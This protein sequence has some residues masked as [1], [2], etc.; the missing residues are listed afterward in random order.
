LTTVVSPRRLGISLVV[1]VVLALGALVMTALEPPADAQPGPPT[2]AQLT[3][4]E[5]VVGAPTPDLLRIIGSNLDNGPNVDVTLGEFPGSLVVVSA[6]A[7]E[8]LAGLPSPLPAGDYLLTVST[9]NGPSRQDSYDLT[10]ERIE[11]PVG[12][13]ILWDQSN[14][15]PDGFARVG[16]YDGRFLVADGAAG[17]TGGSSFHSHG[18]GT[19]NE[20]AHRHLLE[21]WRHVYPPVDDNSGGTDFSTRTG[22]AVGGTMTGTSDPADSRPEFVTILLCRKVAA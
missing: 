21:P 20:S 6:T 18:A 1:V 19:L 12:A 3:I 17:M 9:G 22:P 5:V 2:Q 4:T 11:L 8:I 10:V 16:A 13:I 15:C 14:T 7:T